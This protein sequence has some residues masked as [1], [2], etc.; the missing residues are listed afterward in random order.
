MKE[1]RPRFEHADWLRSAAIHHRRDLG[2]G[3]DGDETAAEL[4]ALADA[5]KPG[6]V[7]GAL[8]AQREQLFEHDRHLLAVRRRQRVE[9]K[10]MS[11][12]RQFL[13]VG[14]AGDRAVDGRELASIRLVPGPD[15]RR[16]VLGGI[17]HS[18]GS[19]SRKVSRGRRR[20]VATHEEHMAENRRVAQGRPDHTRTTVA[21][22][23]VIAVKAT[24]TPRGPRAQRA[25]VG[26]KPKPLLIYCRRDTKAY[27]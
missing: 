14:R 11:A 17:A 12:D 20:A 1:D 27:A 10:G 25:G 5:D 18:R 13:I 8:V 15:F 3:I 7:F 4:L 16:R 19:G 22:I 24:R 6:V 23:R 2:I 26:V 21:H 9:L